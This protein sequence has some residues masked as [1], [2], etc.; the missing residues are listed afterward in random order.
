MSEINTSKFLG[1]QLTYYRKRKGLTQGKLAELMHTT[2]QTISNYERLGI[3][4]TDVEGEISHALG[5]NLREKP[6]DK[7][8]TVGE[9]GKEILF[10]LLEHN[11][12]ISFEELSHNLFGM[13]E[14]R[15]DNM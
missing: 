2:P 14:A 12:Q 5:V 3:K 1:E 9:V 8:G 10:I 13:S 6:A 11:G 7:E 15:I 4:D